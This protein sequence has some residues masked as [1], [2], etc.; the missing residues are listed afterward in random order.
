MNHYKRYLV[1]QRLKREGKRVG[2]FI[3]VYALLLLFL[4][5]CRSKEV[6]ISIPYS[7][8]KLVLWCELKAG[9]PFRIRV[10]KTFNLIGDVPEDLT[11]GNAKVLVIK[12]GKEYVTLTPSSEAGIYQSDSL[13]EQAAAYQIRVLL[14]AYSTAESEPILVPQNIPE[15]NVKREKNVV[16]QINAGIM[17][18]LLSLSFSPDDE[19]KYYMLSFLTYFENHEYIS[20]WAAKDNVIAAEEDCY[21]WMNDELGRRDAIFFVFQ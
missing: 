20:Y 16:G 7:G 17:Q 15:V 6:G 11:V 10:T 14:A 8:D 12:N 18:D 1:I 21:T 2:K 5:S 13:V 19:Q 4:A 3:G 9:K